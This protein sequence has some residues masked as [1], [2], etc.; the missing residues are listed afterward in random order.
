[1]IAAAQ[2]IGS[3]AFASTSTG[4]DIDKAKENASVVR[5]AVEDFPTRIVTDTTLPNGVEVVIQEGTAGERTFFKAVENLRGKDGSFASVPILYDEVTK[6]PTE[7]VVRKG[8]NT[9][10][11]DGISEKTKDSER[12]KAAEKKAEDDKQ[13]A[14]SSNTGSSSN[15]GVSPEST[16]GAPSAARN[17]AKTQAAPASP[18]EPSA[19][20][21]AP[22]P[23]PNGVTSA[24]ENKEYARSILS[25]ADFACTDQLAVRES[26][27]STTATNPSSGAYGV[28]QSLPASKYASAGADWKTNGKTQVN[29]MISYMN[30]RYG[31]PCAALAHSHAVGWY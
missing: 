7:K 25:A 3:A 9:A 28:A 29:W 4:P 16:S 23:A 21:P 20:N 2:I 24:A 18:A 6:L 10:V 5:V 17:A 15:S 14:A 31:S 12:A 26:G 30:E 8:A 11:I 22:A 13:K 27:W 1:M 19:S